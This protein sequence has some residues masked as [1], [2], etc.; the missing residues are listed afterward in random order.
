[1]PIDGRFGADAGPDLTRDLRSHQDVDIYVYPK[2]TDHSDCWWLPVPMSQ[3]CCCNRWSCWVVDIHGIFVFDKFSC[4]LFDF[5]LYGVTCA[6]LNT[7]PV[8]KD[9]L[10][11]SIKKWSGD[12]SY[13]A[14]RWEAGRVVGRVTALV[15]SSTLTGWNCHSETVEEW[16]LNDGGGTESGHLVVKVVMR[17]KLQ[18]MIVPMGSNWGYGFKIKIMVKDQGHWERKCKNG[19]WRIAVGR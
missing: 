10:N 1:M 16:E 13:T 4:S 14:L 11:S 3:C 7:S 9:R 19:C 8:D 15:T 12:I 2:V 5:F 6:I 17:L 18:I